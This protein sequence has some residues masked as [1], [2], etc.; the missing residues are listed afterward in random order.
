MFL[1]LHKTYL[2]RIVFGLVYLIRKKI[3]AFN[4]K[5]DNLRFEE[6]SIGFRPST[7]YQNKVKNWN[8]FT[9]RKILDIFLWLMTFLCNLILN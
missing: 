2:P 4:E 1:F 8:T 7:K 6:K 9:S 3:Y 5:P